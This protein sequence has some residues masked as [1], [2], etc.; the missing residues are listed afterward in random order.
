MDAGALGC[1]I[2]PVVEKIYYKGGSARVVVTAPVR[3]GHPIMIKP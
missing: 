2:D 1:F 3:T